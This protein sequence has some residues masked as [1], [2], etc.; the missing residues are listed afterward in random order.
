MAGPDTEKL[1]YVVQIELCPL[2]GQPTPSPQ[3][4]TLPKLLISDPSMTCP[5][6]S[7][8]ILYNNKQ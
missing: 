5:G 8:T 1:L 3:G 4:Q 7:L 6:D 2:L